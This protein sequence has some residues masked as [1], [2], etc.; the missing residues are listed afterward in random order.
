M[1]HIDTLGKLDTIKLCVAYKLNG[2]IIDYY[3][4]NNKELNLCEPVYE[5]F[6]GWK[7]VD[8][9]RVKRLNALPLS[10][11][12]YVCRIEELIGVPVRYVSVG[13]EREQT[14]TM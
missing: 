6:E 2:E 13:P 9:S 3:P 7:G 12:K 5:E 10:A 14:I 1:N 11:Q 8:I 4:S